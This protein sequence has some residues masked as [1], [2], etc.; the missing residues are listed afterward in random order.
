MFMGDMDIGE[1]FHNFILHEKVQILMGLDLTPFF[2][3]EILI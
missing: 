1:M 3:E 2:L